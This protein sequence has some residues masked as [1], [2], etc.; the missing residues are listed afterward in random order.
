MDTG[1][2]S[3]KF[4]FIIWFWLDKFISSRFSLNCIV[5]I[6]FHDRQQGSI[7]FIITIFVIAEYN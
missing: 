4:I 5:P 2:T 1:N 7:K 6:I 3:V